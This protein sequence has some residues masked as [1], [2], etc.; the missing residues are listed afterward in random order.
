[1][2]ISRSNSDNISAGE[3][4]TKKGYTENEKGVWVE[5]NKRTAEQG[6]VNGVQKGGKGS[7]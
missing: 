7:L 1:M 5:R 4:Q 6:K 3:N 2:Y